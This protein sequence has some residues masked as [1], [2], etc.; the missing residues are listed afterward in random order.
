MAHLNLFSSA[1]PGYCSTV[2][3]NIIILFYTFALCLICFRMFKEE[4]SK[5]GFCSK[6]PDTIGTLRRDASKELFSQ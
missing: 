5:S 3:N 1:N 6:K 4:L 2:F